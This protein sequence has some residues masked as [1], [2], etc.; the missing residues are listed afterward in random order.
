MILFVK[1]TSFSRYQYWKY[2]WGNQDEEAWLFITGDVVYFIGALYLQPVIGAHTVTHLLFVYNIQVLLL[3][4]YLGIRTKNPPSP[5]QNSF[6]I[7]KPLRLCVLKLGTTLVFFLLFYFMLNSIIL[8]SLFPNVSPIS[9][10]IT[11]F[12]SVTQN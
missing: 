5:E 6:P 3:T 1:F 8:W 2:T 10:F 7:C 11:V 12:F 9:N 4:V